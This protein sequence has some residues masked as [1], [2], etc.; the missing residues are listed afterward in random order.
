MN[1]NEEKFK[2]TI[3]EYSP[4]PYICAVP[5]DDVKFLFVNDEGLQQI[6]KDKKIFNQYELQIRWTI[7]KN[8]NLWRV[9]LVKI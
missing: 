3:S 2:I 6:L 9:T 4:S 7:G 8:C 5:L 1:Y